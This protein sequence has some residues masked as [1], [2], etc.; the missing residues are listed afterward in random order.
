MPIVPQQA[1]INRKAAYMQNGLMVEQTRHTEVLSRTGA[2]S[3]FLDKGE[4]WSTDGHGPEVPVL[5]TH[6]YL[7]HIC[8]YTRTSHSMMINI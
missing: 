6:I 5:G 8:T 7:P 3:P 4:I 1:G 2:A